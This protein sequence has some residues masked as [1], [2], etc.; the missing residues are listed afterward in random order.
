MGVE[1]DGNGGRIDKDW[2]ER[3]LVGKLHTQGGGGDSSETI[4]S[5][6]IAAQVC[7]D[8]SIDLKITLH[9]L[10]VP[11]RKKAYMF[12]D[13]KS[14]MDSSTISHSKLHKQHNALSF[15]CIQE[16][17]AS[18]ILAFY[19]IEGTKNPADILN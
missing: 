18:G 14:V 15:R 12:G 19:H 10:G 9:Y 16:A 3:R 2:G 17:I 11:V 6:F 5:E 4:G 7:A 13:N 1:E 8:Q